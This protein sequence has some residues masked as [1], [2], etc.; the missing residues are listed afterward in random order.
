MMA[1]ETNP[2]TSI[3]SAT[4]LSKHVANMAQCSRRDAE[5]YIQGGWVQVDGIVIDQPQFMVRDQ[6]VA[7]AQSAQLAPIEAV[8]LLL[9]QPADLAR[10]A[11][12]A[13]LNAT[14]RSP[15]DPANTPVLARHFSKLHALMPL[16]AQVSGMTMFTQ[17]RRFATSLGADFGRFEEEYVVEVQGDIAPYG[18]ARLRHGLQFKGRILPPIKVSWQNEVRLRFALNG[19]LPGQLQ[20]MCADVGLSVMAIKRIRIGRIALAK[21]LPGEWRYLEPRERF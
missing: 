10:D 11:A 20:S 14:S 16:V 4:R 15:S 5:L 19:V 3:D 8:T 2:P 12:I 6:H 17:D 21:I 9:N 7:L 13:L 18:L 1:P